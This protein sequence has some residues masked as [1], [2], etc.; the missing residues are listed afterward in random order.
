MLRALFRKQ[1]LELN[2]GFFQNKKTGKA[3][4]RAGTVL[5]IVSFALLMIVVL[6]GMFLYVAYGMC[7]M[8]REGLSW[9]YFLIMGLIAAALGI[10]GSVFNTYASLYRAKDN[11]LL[12]SLPIPVRYIL[13]VRLSGVYLMGLLYSMIVYVPAVVIYYI[14]E[15]LTVGRVLAPLW[16]GLLISVFVL[17]LSCILGWVVANING[18]LKHKS[19][20]TVFVS[21]AFMTAY[22]FVYFRANAFLGELAQN[23]V[24]AADVIQSKAKVLYLLG[25]AATGNPLSVLVTTACV[26][27]LLAV[28][29]VVMGRSFLRIATTPDK[30]KRVRYQEKT[31]RVR[32]IRSALLW[33]EA[34]RFLASPTY[35]LNCALG[36]FFMVILGIVM[37]VKSAWIRQL[38]GPNVEGMIVLF[39]ESVSFDLIVVIVTAGMCAA[40]SMNDISIVSVTL[41]GKNL[42]IARSLPVTTRQILKSKLE[43]P[44]LLTGIPAIF[45]AVCAWIVF[46]FDL[47]NGVLMCLVMLAYG[48]LNDTAG[49][50]LNLRN[51]KLN[52]T[53]EVAA[54]KQNFGVVIVIFGGWFLLVLVGAL[55]IFCGEQIGSVGFLTICLIVFGVAAGMLRG[56]IMRKG[57]ARFEQL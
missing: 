15:E 32:S 54:I 30:I 46:G 22:Y 35:I 14:F 2:Q 56:W 48:Y 11:D 47:I 55:Y 52:W 7:G 6:G 49:L 17:I 25:N 33:K 12:L 51:P 26:L 29:L 27:L 13:V 39:G 20:V 21:L 24:K 38:I 41:E 43:L 40:V 8:I 3:R 1:M 44:M 42:W 23:S 50:A 37:L 4:S 16:Y 9:L 57:A 36:T 45:C 5:S 10:F 19:L 34:A 18:K 28:T 31:S 53:S